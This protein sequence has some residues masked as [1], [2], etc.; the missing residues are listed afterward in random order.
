MAGRTVSLR[1]Y[2]RV[3]E[4]LELKDTQIKL[5][6][7]QNATLLHSLNTVEVEHEKLSHEKNVL[8]GLNISLKEKVTDNESTIQILQD[9]PKR[10]QS[11]VVDAESKVEIISKQNTDLVRMARDHGDETQINS[12]KQRDLNVK[13]EYSKKAG[14]KG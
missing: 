9:R 12:E 8:H 11:L 2:E 13:V 6:T 1:Q 10:H 7:D 5:L 14:F 4:S 3:R